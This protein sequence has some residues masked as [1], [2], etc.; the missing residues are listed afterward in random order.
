MRVSTL[1]IGLLI[2][3]TGAVFALQGAGFLPGS[4][5]TGDRLW[6]VIGSVMVVVGVGLAAWSRQRA[7]S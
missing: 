5:M 2:A 1:V 6:L 4:Y 7:R 3:L